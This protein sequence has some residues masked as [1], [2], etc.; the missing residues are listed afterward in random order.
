[1]A[2]TRDV[3][4]YNRKECWQRYNEMV[5]GENGRRL[6]AKVVAQG[7]QGRMRDIPK[8]IRFLE[9]FQ[10]LAKKDVDMIARTE[11]ARAMCAGNLKAAIEVGCTEKEWIGYEACDVC[12]ANIA[13]GR[14]PFK[15]PF[16]SGDKC[17]PAHP[18]DRCDV[19]YMG[20]TK[21]VR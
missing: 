15:T 21:L 12:Q 19:A 17:P 16:A 20:A 4:Q 8:L 2:K 7:L 11:I 13:Q 5:G 10:H 14:I 18:G 1:M 6:L 9:P 3:E